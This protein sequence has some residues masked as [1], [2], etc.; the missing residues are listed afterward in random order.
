MKNKIYLCSFASDDLNL[1]VSRFLS[2][3]KNMN[4]YNDIKIFRPKD[5]SE[6]LKET[7]SISA[8]KTIYSK[9]YHEHIK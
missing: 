5:L 3:A 9:V 4:I 2:Q 1:S 8:I 6:K 7:H